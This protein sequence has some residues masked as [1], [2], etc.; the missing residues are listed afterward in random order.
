MLVAIPGLG[1][2]WLGF[3]PGWGWLV[4]PMFPAMPVSFGML[5]VMA[6]V[7]VSLGAGLRLVLNNL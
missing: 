1:W 3:P 7:L 5:V 6:L 2:W 4:L